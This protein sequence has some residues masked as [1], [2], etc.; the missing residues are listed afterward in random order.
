MDEDSVFGTPIQMLGFVLVP[1]KLSLA[2]GLPGFDG[3]V[4]TRGGGGKH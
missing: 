2:L 4:S 3:F 1:V